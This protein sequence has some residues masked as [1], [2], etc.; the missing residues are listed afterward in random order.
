VLWDRDGRLAEPLLARLAAAGFFVGDNEPYSGE[1]ENDCLYRHGTMN[2]L[3]H[4]LIEIRQDLIGDDAAARAFALRLKPILAAALDDMG[5]AHI[6][7]TRP[8]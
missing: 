7:F 3:P 5:R 8:L 6:H 4:V 1:L 2:G